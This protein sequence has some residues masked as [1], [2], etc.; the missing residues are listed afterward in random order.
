MTTESENKLNTYLITLTTGHKKT[1]KASYYKEGDRNFVFYKPSDSDARQ[2]V[3]HYS[4]PNVISV[5]LQ[6]PSHKESSNKECDP[7]P[8]MLEAFRLASIQA[9]ATFRVLEGLDLDGQSNG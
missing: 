6:E 9:E 7:R 2:T 3:A 4:I 5:V 8:E 1:V